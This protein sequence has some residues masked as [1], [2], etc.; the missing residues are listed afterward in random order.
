MAMTYTMWMWSARKGDFLRPRRIRCVAG[1]VGR[2]GI[3]PGHMPLMTRIKPGAVCVSS[4]RIN[5][6]KS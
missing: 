6:K 4:F 3:L 1:R 2:V 5:R